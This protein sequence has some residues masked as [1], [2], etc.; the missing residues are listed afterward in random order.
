MKITRKDIY[1]FEVEFAEKEFTKIKEAA[2][3][4]GYTIEEVLYDVLQAVFDNNFNT[5]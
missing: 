5:N 4:D 1:N 3:D 2:D